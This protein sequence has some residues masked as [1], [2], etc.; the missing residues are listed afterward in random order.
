MLDNY[1][2]SPSAVTAG[3]PRTRKQICEDLARTVRVAKSL[4]I[5]TIIIFEGWG[6]SGKGH[7]IE[8]LISELDPRGFKVATIRS[9]DDSELRYPMLHRFWK[10]LPSKGN[11]AI[12]DR[13][14]YREVSTAYIDSTVCVEENLPKKMLDRNFSDILEF[15]RLLADDGYVIIKFFLNITKK[16]QAERF[17]RLE[18]SK[19]TSWRVTADDWRRNKRY[20]EYYAAFS[21]MITR[22]DTEYAPWR[23]L[24]AG[25]M[26]ATAKAICKL[27]DDRLTAEI[28]ARQAKNSDT[29]RGKVK[30][31]T[32]SDG[33]DYTSAEKSHTSPIPPDIRIETTIEPVRIKPL[34]EYDL[35][36]D[37]GA[38][39]YKIKLKQLQSELFELHNKLYKKK[40][41]LII[42]FEGWDAAGKGGAIKRLTAGFD[43]RGYEVIP[44]AAPTPTELSYHYLRRF[45][46]TLPKSG[47]IG[48]YDRSWYG[49]VMVERL[50]GFAKRDEWTRAYDE[51]NKFERTLT[52]AGAIVTK[53][54]LHIDDDEQLKRFNERM[55]DPD[56]RWKITDEDWRN[57]D[58]RV[59]YHIA[60]DQMLALT[61]TD[62]A[63]WYVI[64]AN[65]KRYARLRVL[66]CVINE[67]R[68][69]L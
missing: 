57:R 23:V 27:V 41:P 18:A 69:R 3:D 10:K 11:I 17:E 50:E 31:L 21:D 25:D 54:W 51:I 63:P 46:M 13:S 61:N 64:E 43:P 16:E 12:F 55:S 66:E 38:D 20:K 5:P 59:G 26:K 53:F 15:E 24:D 58:K 47:H 65:S 8:K 68:S 4:Q 28:A 39:E 44:I 14:W 45:W 56:K 19:A 22:T 29:N 30:D 36:L 37:I 7:M 6:A 1:I 40:I 34:D 52:R 33:I 49:R 62:Y 2:V 60:A 42:A 48:I 35:S 67:V 9:A 32:I